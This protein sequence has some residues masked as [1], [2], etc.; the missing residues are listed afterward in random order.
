MSAPR[1]AFDPRGD[2]KRQPDAPDRAVRPKLAAT[3]V[4]LDETGNPRV[5]MG[6]RH[7]ATRFMPH[8]Y[9]FPGGRVDRGDSYA[10][11]AGETHPAALK[12]LDGALTAR[13]VR[14][15]AA[16]AIRETFE[17][18]GYAI[19]Q[20]LEARPTGPKDWRDFYDCAGAPDI[21]PLRLIARAVTPPYRPI[22]YDA[23]F[24][25]ADAARAT[26]IEGA[27][28]EEL[29]ETDWVTLDEAEALDIPSIT[30]FVLGEVR[31]R[32]DTP[33]APVPYIRMEKGR[34]IWTPLPHSAETA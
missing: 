17:E 9:V 7:S 13:R 11:T 12:A 5:L 27:C 22:R 21:S 34:H 16:A 26:H 4:L 6:K 1:K 24:F 19:A 31:R 14:A 30:R 8:K 25:M 3:L 29:L 18:T 32:L 2:E 10:R 33:D 15:A 28:T 20:A 23:L